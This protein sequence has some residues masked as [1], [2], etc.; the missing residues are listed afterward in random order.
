MKIIIE[1]HIDKD[2][3]QRGDWERDG[4]SQDEILAALEDC[5]V[6][7]PNEFFHG[8]KWKLVDGNGKVTAVL[9]PID[10]DEYEDE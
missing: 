1:K 7:E 8:T 6:F 3:W 10:S 4:K 5:F 2:Y 9:G